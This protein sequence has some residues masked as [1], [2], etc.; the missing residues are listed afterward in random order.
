[1]NQALSDG[2]ANRLFWLGRYAERTYLTLHFL[3]RAYDLLI[4][5]DRA[6]FARLSGILDPEGPQSLTLFEF[7]QDH[8]FDEKRE[9]S[10]VS[11]LRHADDNA[12]ELR[13]IIKSESLSYIQMAVCHL[14]RLS[15][16][17]EA[18]TVTAL[19]KITD[20]VLA[21]Y[22]STEERLLSRNVVAYVRYGRFIESLDMHLRFGYPYEA[23]RGVTDCLKRWSV[24]D[25]SVIDKYSL[26]RFDSM[27]SES[28]YDIEN[29]DYRSKMI[30]TVNQI[31]R[32]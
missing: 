25:D 29:G 9:T 23:V 18:L 32:I 12:I 27:L 17:P 2:N 16:H 8:I 15:E 3:R 26:E 20:C 13:E 6:E 10:L 22:G 14:K 28:L 11:V 21:F 31:V 19:Q 24:I 4:D 30:A 7:A 1:M 5:G